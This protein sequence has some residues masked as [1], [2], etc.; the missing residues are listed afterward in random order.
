MQKNLWRE[1]KNCI[2]P[3]PGFYSKKWNTADKQTPLLYF[4]Q[5][6]QKR[7]VHLETSG[8]TGR[9]FRGEIK[10]FIDPMLYL[11]FVVLPEQY[12]DETNYF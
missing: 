4:F 1:Q 7:P 2:K 5:F 6:S 9:F 11:E 12:N 8:C 10:I 3:P